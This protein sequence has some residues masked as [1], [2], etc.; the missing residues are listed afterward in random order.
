[1]HDGRGPEALRELQ[2][3]AGDHQNNEADEKYRMLDPFIERE[4][5]RPGEGSVFRDVPRNL[6]NQSR[7]L[8]R[9]M[10]PRT[11]GMVNR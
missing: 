10:K 1:M 3:K 7:R 4:A 6:R 11:D 8:W 5:Q 2:G 9:I